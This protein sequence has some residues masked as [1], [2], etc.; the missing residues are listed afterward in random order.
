[1]TTTTTKVIL[2]TEIKLSLHIDPIGGMTM[3][4]YDFEV[5]V[6][7]SP[8]R[9]LH[10]AKDALVRVSKYDRLVC[11][12]TAETGAGRLYLRVVA[13][14]PDGDFADGTRTEVSVVDT[15]IEITK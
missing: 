5:E 2:G 11:V 13:Y 14:I 8:R 12:P 7:T 9:K 4:D 15:Y 10:F 6:Y 1:M 3:D